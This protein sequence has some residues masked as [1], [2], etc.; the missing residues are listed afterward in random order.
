MYLCEPASAVPAPAHIF[1]GSSEV[2]VLSP[3][4]LISTLILL[5]ID[6]LRAGQLLSHLCQLTT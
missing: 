2:R 4:L 6:L 3:P 1:N 5:L